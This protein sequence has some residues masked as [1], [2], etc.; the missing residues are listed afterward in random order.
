MH[1][2]V[3]RNGRVLDFAVVK[4]T[5]YPD[6]DAAI[7]DMMRGANLPPFPPDMTQSRVSVSVA[8]RFSLTR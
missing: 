4:S 1:F 3:D 7:E 6:L 5:G 2:E 8:I